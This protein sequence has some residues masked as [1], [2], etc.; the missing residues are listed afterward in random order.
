MSLVLV[1]GQIPSRH[2]WM[3]LDLQMSVR[4]LGSMLVLNLAFL[5]GSVLTDPGTSGNFP[6]TSGFSCLCGPRLPDSGPFGF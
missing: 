3:V 1:E 4:C 6:R 2:D 5:L